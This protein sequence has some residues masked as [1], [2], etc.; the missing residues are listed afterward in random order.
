M[1]YVKSAV[2]MGFMK[3]VA[4]TS[5]IDPGPLRRAFFQSGPG[6]TTR[7][8]P[9]ARLLADIHCLS[10][11]RHQGLTYSIGIAYLGAESRSRASAL[12]SS[13]HQVWY[14]FKSSALHLLLLPDFSIAHHP[15]LVQLDYHV[16]ISILCYVKSAVLNHGNTRFM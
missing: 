4:Y 6:G 13:L 3:L 5:L 12:H 9:P 11:T 7:L 10:H 16:H 15:S 14:L 8:V 1:G 2:L